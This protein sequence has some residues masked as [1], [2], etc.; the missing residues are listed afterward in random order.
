[1]HYMC[2]QTSRARM[3]ISISATARLV[4]ITER[5]KGIAAR[6]TADLC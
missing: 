3:L 2:N 5:S 6:H 1:M 4:Y